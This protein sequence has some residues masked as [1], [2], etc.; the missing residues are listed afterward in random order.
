[1]LLFPNAKIN[2]GLSVTEK[3]NDGFHNLETV[4]YPVPLKDALEIIPHAETNMHISG[5]AVAGNSTHNLV[6]KAH[7]LLQQLYPNKVGQFNIYLHK[8]IPMGAGLGGGSSDASF[9]LR[10]LNEACEL[11]LSITTLQALALQLGSDC[12]FFIENTVAFASGRGEKLE[13]IE[14]DLSAYNIVLVCP[15]LH[16]STAQAFAGIKPTAAIF[17]LRKLQQLPIQNWKDRVVND[18]ENSLFSIFPDLA[19]I[20]QQLYHQG[21]LYASLSGTG[22]TVYGIFPRGVHTLHFEDVS[23]PYTLHVM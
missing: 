2:I 15:T 21:A 17:D 5:L 18:F 19:S 9:M 14:L 23:V 3:R 11:N 13:P 10:M 22:S 1:M 4:F 6:W 20:K 7:A 16:I 8:R 12:P